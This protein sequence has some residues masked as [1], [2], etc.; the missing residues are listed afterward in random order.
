MKENSRRSSR[1]LR[2]ES[3]LET[4]YETINN[5]NL[6]LKSAINKWAADHYLYGDAFVEVKT[7]RPQGEKIQ[8]VYSGTKSLSGNAG[9][10][11]S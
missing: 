6:D 8:G 9:D 1:N 10:A 11:D 4:Y 2:K 3:L 5:W 7:I